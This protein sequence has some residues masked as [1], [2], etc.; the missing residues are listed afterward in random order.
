MVVI[1]DVVDM[2]WPFG[3]SCVAIVA[4]FVCAIAQHSIQCNDECSVQVPDG[5]F[6]RTLH[7]QAQ[8]TIRIAD[9]YASA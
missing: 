7:G 4:Q 2:M 9:S 8:G 3:F 5:L 1:Y 6:L